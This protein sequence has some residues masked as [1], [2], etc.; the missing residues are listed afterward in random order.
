MNVV[1]E[2]RSLCVAMVAL[3]VLTGAY[4]PAGVGG[5]R[6][7][8]QSGKNF[9]GEKSPSQIC[10]FISSAWD[11]LTRSLDKCKTFE[12]QKTD[13]ESTLYLPA[14][15]TEPAALR[16]L[17]Q[18]KCRVDVKP[19]PESISEHGELDNSKIQTE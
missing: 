1:Q 19:L 14:E 5:N 12:D 9:G 11:T 18:D 8:E 16:Q 17:V 2:K 7:G 15:I 10:A 6:S 13:A 4:P 3:V